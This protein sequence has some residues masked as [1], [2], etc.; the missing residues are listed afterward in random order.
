MT[1]TAPPLTEKSMQEGIL[2]E[3]K[4]LGYRCY[5]TY[6]SIRSE[7]GYPDL[8]IVGHGQLFIFE[9]KGPR[10]KTSDAQFAWIEA[11]QDAGIVAMIVWPELY[12]AALELLQEAAT[13]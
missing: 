13:T 11:F 4:W 9:I 8:T 7:A 12:E 10:G 2:E 5:H 1:T 3:A 6:S